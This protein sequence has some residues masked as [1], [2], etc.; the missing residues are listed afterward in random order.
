MI[1]GH[2]IPLSVDTSHHPVSITVS[3][4]P[5]SVDAIADEIVRR[6]FVN[7]NGE[8]GSRLVLVDPDKRDLGGWCPM[9][10]RTVVRDVLSEIK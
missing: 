10:V 7:G 8:H 4:R 6:L 3:P 1:V 5:V 9:A 2:V